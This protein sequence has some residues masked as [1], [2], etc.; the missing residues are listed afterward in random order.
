MR[1]Q[2]VSLIPIFMINVCFSREC[3]HWSNRLIYDYIYIHICAI[4]T[5]AVSESTHL[6]NNL[7]LY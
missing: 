2:T 7:L 1:A 5:S 4:H 6:E 3:L